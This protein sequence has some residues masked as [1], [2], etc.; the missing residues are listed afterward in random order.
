MKIILI[1]ERLKGR[2][3]YNKKLLLFADAI[4]LLAIK[5]TVFQSQILI[6]LPL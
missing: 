2:Y 6:F 4:R 5:E 1:I 3:T